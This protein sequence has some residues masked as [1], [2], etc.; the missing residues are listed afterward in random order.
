MS[1]KSRVLYAN[2]AC[3]QLWGE[4]PPG[5]DASTVLRKAN[6][7]EG[8]WELGMRTRQE[9]RFATNGK[10]IMA[11][12]VAARLLGERDALNVISFHPVRES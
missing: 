10:T 6:L 1:A 5:M 12:C 11:T 4:M 8:W 3:K 7:P 9:R 2:P